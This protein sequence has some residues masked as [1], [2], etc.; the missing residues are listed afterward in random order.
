M[1]DG[2]GNYVIVKP[3]QATWNKYQEKANKSAAA[4][5]EEARGSR[6]LQYMGLECP[7][8]KRLFVEPTKTPC[9]QSI[10]CK[11][12]ITNALLDEDLRCPN[13]GREGIIIDNLMPAD[14]KAVEVQNFKNRRDYAAQRQSYRASTEAI[15][16]A[17]SSQSSIEQPSLTIPN[18]VL[19]ATD[20][21]QDHFTP[22]IGQ[23][24]SLSSP[25]ELASRKRKADAQPEN[26]RKSPAV[27]SVSTVNDITGP[28]ED[29]ASAKL[30]DREPPRGPRALVDK[31]IAIQASSNNP[32]PGL[33][34]G[35]STSIGPMMNM[36]PMMWDSMAIFNPFG[37]MNAMYS[38]L[39]H[40]GLT[41]QG[42]NVPDF[43]SQS[44]GGGRRGNRQNLRGNPTQ[45]FRTFNASRPNP[46]ENAYFRSPVNPHRY[47]NRRNIP[48]P[49]D[50]REI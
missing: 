31:G 22:D 13:C 5:E 18:P 21:P 16:P 44:F 34:A 25:P 29:L 4:Q 48:R 1:I 43:Q 7:I 49:T 15:A 2:D 45:P 17:D 41:S 40:P 50:Y 9:C 28:G 47:Q 24:A 27:M 32:S 26:N 30:R 46:E 23:A 11:E 10:Y 6:E 8:D 19:Q 38:P 20:A 36:M 42:I 12:C 39:S 3:D 33:P 14:E 37:A 35:I